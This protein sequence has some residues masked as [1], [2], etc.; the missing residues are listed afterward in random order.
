MGFVV[1]VEILFVT[2]GD[3]CYGCVLFGSSIWNGEGYALLSG[4]DCFAWRSAQA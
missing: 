4:C 3:N 2:A 1:G